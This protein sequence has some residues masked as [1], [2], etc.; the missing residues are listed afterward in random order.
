MVLQHRKVPVDSLHRIL[1][2][3]IAKRKCVKGMTFDRTSLQTH[4]IPFLNFLI[5]TSHL[6][7]YVTKAIYLKMQQIRI[8]L[9]KLL[10]VQ[11]G[12]IQVVLE[13]IL[14]RHLWR[15]LGISQDSFIRRD[16]ESRVGFVLGRCGLV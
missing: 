14:R 3:S 1:F 10:V 16:E 9:D 4:L 8:F 11:D 5:K 6:I 2:Q 15:I 7:I 13:K 12:T